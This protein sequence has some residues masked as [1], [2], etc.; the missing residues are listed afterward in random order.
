MHST[1]STC[2]DFYHQYWTTTKTATTTA[3][4]I[5]VLSEYFYKNAKTLKILKNKHNIEIG[6]Y[7]SEIVEKFFQHSKKIIEENVKNNSIYKKIYD[8]W[9]SSILVFNEYHKYSDNEYLKLRLRNT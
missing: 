2:Y 5:E 6:H 1:I 9:K 8:D 3:N 7:S 4:Y